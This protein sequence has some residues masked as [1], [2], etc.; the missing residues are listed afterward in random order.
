MKRAN[1]KSRI[2][3]NVDRVDSSNSAAKQ[4]ETENGTKRKKCSLQCAMNHRKIFPLAYAINLLWNCVLD[5]TDTFFGIF[6]GKTRYLAF[7]FRRFNSILKCT[8]AEQY[9]NEMPKRLSKQ[10]KFGKFRAFDKFFLFWSIETK[11]MQKTNHTIKPATITH[12]YPARY[13]Q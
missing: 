7:G 8:C 6:I 5:G 11:E 3:T 13:T 10:M 1:K 4:W 9:P 2:S 12:E